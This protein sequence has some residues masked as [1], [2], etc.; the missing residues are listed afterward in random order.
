MV[1]CEWLIRCHRYSWDFCS[2]SFWKFLVQKHFWDIYTAILYLCRYTSKT[3]IHLICW[4]GTTCNCSNTSCVFLVI[5]SKVTW[6]LLWSL[7]WVNPFPFWNIWPVLFW[8]RLESTPARIK[9]IELIYKWPQI[10]FNISNFKIG[11][12]VCR[13]PRI[14]V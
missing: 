11:I 7:F 8:N 1:L 13:H 14:Y 9:L 3:G 5:Y 2:L 4:Y 6:P 12:L 10:L